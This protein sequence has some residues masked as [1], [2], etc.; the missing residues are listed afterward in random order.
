MSF[1]SLHHVL[2]GFQNQSQHREQH[3]LQQVVRCWVDVVGPVVAVQ[4]R[5]LNIYRGV[6]KV[7]TS[8]AAWAQNLVFERQRILDKLK[9][10][11]ALPITDI[12]FSPAHW[13]DKPVASFPGDQFQHEL[14]QA[15]PSRFSDSNPKKRLNPPLQPGGSELED[16]DAISAFRQWSAHM[17]LRSRN[18]PLCPECHCPTPKG[19]LERW[20]VCGICVA[21]RWS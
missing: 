11:T 20:A 19:E 9:Q 21:K 1:R 15:H 8:S 5:P 6:L 10:I 7:A 4:T 18:L 2:G 16:K 13:Q 12:R 14:W 17:R 3:Q